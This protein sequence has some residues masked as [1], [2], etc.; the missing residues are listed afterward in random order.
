MN[1]S[2]ILIFTLL[3]ILPFNKAATLED[4]KDLYNAGNYK[5][6]YPI[7]LET[8]NKN[9]KN[10]SVNQWLGVCLFKENK[11]YD[12]QKYFV[13]ASSKGI[14]DAPYYL[15]MVYF[16]EG[17]YKKAMQ[18]LVIYEN[19]VKKT[20]KSIPEEY[21]KGI[22]SIKLAQPMLDH[23]EEIVI[24]DSIVVDKNDFFKYYKISPEIGTFQSI[25]VLPKSQ[26]D[27]RNPV[28]VP[29]SNERMLWSGTI[30]NG[31]DSLYQSNKLTD[32]SWDSPHLIDENMNMGA[33]AAYPF[34][35]PDGASLYFASN[36]T[37]SIGGYDI[38]VAGKDLESGEYYKPQ[39]VG[40]PYN[41]PYDDY[42]MV[43]DEI[44]GAGWWATD[45]NQIPDKVTIYIFKPNSIRKNY[46]ADND[47]LESLSWIRNIRDTWVSGEDYSDLLEAIKNIDTKVSKKKKDF[48]FVLYSNIVYTTMSDFKSSEARS[49]MSVW[50][51]DCKTMAQK[52][53]KLTDLRSKYAKTQS[54]ELTNQI[55][56]LENDINIL[57]D[58]IN[59]T[60]NNIRKSE[61]K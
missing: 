48:E 16:Y 4:A 19:N 54:S 52:Q 20:K 45:R 35:M 42:L 18:E 58:S 34:M 44:T 46:G 47:N 11:Y 3:F 38:F 8:Y 60:A 51:K 1:R 5:D 56:S 40:L 41:S 22:N 33:D 25:S 9:P 59:K 2:I 32:G 61:L 21:Q 14:M 57:R 15:G 6:A 28:Y 55:L 30:N 29:E 27:S 12:A 7:F 39:N 36:G 23:V 26:L 31:S 43:I 24:I 17:Q 13:F 49:L 53:A 50:I 10:A 37:G